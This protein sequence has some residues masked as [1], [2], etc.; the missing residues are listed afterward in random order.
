MTFDKEMEKENTT[1]SKY[2]LSKIKVKRSN[3]IASIKENWRFTVD[4]KTKQK[5]NN[6]SDKVSSSATYSS[7]DK[8]TRN[9]K[10]IDR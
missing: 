8:Y 9:M 2:L 6:Q 1:S 10:V 3:V 4:N 5:T 7:A